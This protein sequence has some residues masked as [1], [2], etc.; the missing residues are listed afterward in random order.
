MYSK[1]FLFIKVHFS[2]LFN[3]VFT[4]DQML[5][6]IHLCTVMVSVLVLFIESM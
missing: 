1:R 5:Y 3:K 4:R 2:P 6:R